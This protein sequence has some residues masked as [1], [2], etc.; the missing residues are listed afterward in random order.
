MANSENQNFH[1]QT[2]LY[3]SPFSLFILG[4]RTIGSEMRWKILE[5]IRLWEIKQLQKRL[6]KEYELL[7]QLEVQETEGELSSEQASEKELCHKQVEFLQEEIDFLQKALQ[8]TR[9]EYIEQRLSAWK[10]EY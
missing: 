7:G 10:L 4:L 8:R 6:Y 1:T 5:A 2:T 9:K 3:I